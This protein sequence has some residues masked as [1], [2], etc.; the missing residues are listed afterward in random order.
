[1][2]QTMESKG[3]KT[4]L[5]LNQKPK[6]IRI[7][8]EVQKKVERL[9]LSANKKK[10]GRK[11]KVDQLLSLALDLVSDEHI[12]KLQEQS[13]SNEDRKE[14]LRQRYIEIRGPIS[15]DEFTG[16]MLTKEFSEFLAEQSFAASAA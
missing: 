6:S 11:I 7:N 2:E 5:K 3:T 14:Q 8:S 16:F 15:R 10:A 13:L 4:N 1:M 9:L 12:K